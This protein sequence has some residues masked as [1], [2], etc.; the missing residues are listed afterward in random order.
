MSGNEIVISEAVQLGVVQ[1]S[2]PKDVIARASDM[3]VVLADI[4]EKKKL[5]TPINGKK[6]VRVDG[7][8]TLGAMLGVLPHEVRSIK[9]DNGYEAYVEL[10]RM[11]DG[12]VIGGSSAIC[13]RDERNWSNRDEYAIKSMATTRATGKAYRLAF[14]WIMNMAGY[15]STP[16]E[17]MIDAEVIESKQKPAQKANQSDTESTDK[18]KLKTPMSIKLAEQAKSSDGRFYKDIPDD[19]LAKKRLG[20]ISYLNNKENKDAEQIT[21]HKYSMDAILTIEAYRK[22]NRNS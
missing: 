9:I 14:S 2:S 1:A 15:E 10:I 7:W 12:A 6:Y 18:P 5:Y 17:E 11:T 3:A 22:A 21:A 13:T 8:S 20:H 16:A 19:E 4:I